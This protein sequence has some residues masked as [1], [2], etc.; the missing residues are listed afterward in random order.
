MYVKYVETSS[1]AYPLISA[2]LHHMMGLGWRY[3]ARL[4]HAVMPYWHY[5]DFNFVVIPAI[6]RLAPAC[7]LLSLATPKAIPF[8]L[9]T[10]TFCPA[11][12]PCLRLPILRGCDYARLHRSDVRTNQKTLISSCIRHIVSKP[13]KLHLVT[14]L[15]IIMWKLKS[16]NKFK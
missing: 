5:K 13:S 8:N 7:Q 11:H 16:D 1:F 15:R 10:L 14:V 6:I 12:K 2:N 3:R 4:M 9:C